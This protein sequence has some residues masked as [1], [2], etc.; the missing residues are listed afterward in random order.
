[1]GST[2]IEYLTAIR[3]EKAKTLLKSTNLSSLEI[4]FTVGFS[5]SNYFS[6][7]FKKITSESPRSY[8]KRKVD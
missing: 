8:K 2:F 5:D 4:A 1:M 3:I 6:K 7:I